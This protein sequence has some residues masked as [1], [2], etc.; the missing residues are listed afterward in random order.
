[1]I[2]LVCDLFEQGEDTC[3]RVPAFYRL[4]IIDVGV[5]LN[6]R[7]YDFGQ[8]LNYRGSLREIVVEYNFDKERFRACSQLKWH[9]EFLLLR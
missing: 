2:E 4:S 1:M 5:F 6:E 8:N 9:F 3:L 7:M